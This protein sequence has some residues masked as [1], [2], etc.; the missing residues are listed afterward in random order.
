MDIVRQAPD[1]FYNDKKSGTFQVDLLWSVGAQ[2][3]LLPGASLA[4][5]T[6]LVS[7]DGE[8]VANQKILKVGDANNKLVCG[9]KQG[10]TRIV[11]GVPARLSM[12]INQV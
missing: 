10:D 3:S 1:K 9:T 11:P 4:I 12:R 2:V 8:L 5:T 7:E 6:S